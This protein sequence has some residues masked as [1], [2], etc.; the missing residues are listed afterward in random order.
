M[1]QLP[2]LTVTDAQAARMLAAYGTVDAYKAWLIEQI[3]GHVL[4]HEQK[5]MATEALEQQRTAMAAL[6]AELEGT[7]TTSPT[8]TTVAST[9]TSKK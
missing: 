2:T 1:P 4:D 6:R 9:E 3:I 8:T 5:R 7:A